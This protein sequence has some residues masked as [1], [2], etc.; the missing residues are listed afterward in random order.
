[1]FLGTNRKF[2]HFVVFYRYGSKSWNSA[3]V[4]VVCL[5]RWTEIER[6]SDY[7]LP[8]WQRWIDGEETELA[9]DLSSLTR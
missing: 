5:A 9:K 2:E 4:C 7:M 6:E 8:L 1:M 3:C